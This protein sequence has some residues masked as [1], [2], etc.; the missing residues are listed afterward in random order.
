MTIADKLQLTNHLYL[1]NWNIQLKMYQMCIWSNIF[2][3]KIKLKI[4]INLQNLKGS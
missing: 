2:S 1:Y 4:K 3:F